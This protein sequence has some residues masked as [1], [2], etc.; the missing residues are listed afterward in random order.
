MRNLFLAIIISIAVLANSMAYAAPVLINFDDVAGSN[1]DITN[2]YSG[3]GVTLGA[4]DNPFP[5][6]GPFPATLTLPTVRA[7]VQTWTEGFGSATSPRQVAVASQFSG[8]A[9]PGD[10]GIL[11]S[12]D[13]DVNFL[14]LV[15]NDVG[16]CPLP[17]D[18]ESVTLT[19]Y[20]AAGNRIG[21]TFT[22]TKLAGFDRTLAS[23][24]IAGMRHVAFNYTDTP[25]GFYAIDDLTFEASP[26]PA[27]STMFLMG[28]GLVGLATWRYRKGM[29]V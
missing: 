12:F 8:A 14:S 22:S 6:S 24:A 27:P 10:G 1:Q 19:A 9:Q 29:K 16:G 18:C 3:L 2:R 11:I 5:L 21:Q 4:I 25:F 17:G 20:N 15:G 28:T 7:G 26:I 13:F 23:I